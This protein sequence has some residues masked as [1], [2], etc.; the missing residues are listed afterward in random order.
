VTELAAEHHQGVVE[1]AALLQIL[2]QR[3]GGLVDVPAL[4]R[5]LAI[6]IVRFV[7]MRVP[8]LPRLE[9]F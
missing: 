8:S 5:S 1:Q 3:G 2:Q 4:K 9:A 6:R 7:N